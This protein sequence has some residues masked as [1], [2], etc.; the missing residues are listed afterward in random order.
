MHTL[1]L[2]GELDHASAPKLEAEIERVCEMGV[3]GITLDLSQLTHIDASGVAVI[4]F[5]SR[6]C[7]RRGYE[8][9]LLPGREA[10]QEAFERA[11]VGEE[12]P[13]VR[14]DGVTVATVAAAP[15]SPA[16]R[17]VSVVRTT[18]SFSRRRS[19]A[20]GVSGPAGA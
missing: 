7:Q 8:F 1:V 17:S 16:S 4:A 12:L 10:V 19:A 2:L 11:G 20:Q 14:G 3:E 5:R 9:A 13:F 18:S 6:L 15:Q